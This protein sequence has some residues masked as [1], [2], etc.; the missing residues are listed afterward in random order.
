MPNAKRGSFSSAVPAD[1]DVGKREYA[2]QRWGDALTD[3]AAYIGEDLHALDDHDPNFDDI[4]D[5]KYA[6]VCARPR[7][8]NALIGCRVLMGNFV[9][10]TPSAVKRVVHSSEVKATVQDLVHR[11]LVSYDTD[12]FTTQLEEINNVSWTYEIPKVP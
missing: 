2:G 6:A 4:Q 10:P 11:F 3:D 12:A 9:P 1:A 5:Q 7:R 8:T